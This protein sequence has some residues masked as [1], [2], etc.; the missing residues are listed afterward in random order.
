MNNYNIRSVT[1]IK[2]VT[3]GQSFCG[4][5]TIVNKLLHPNETILAEITL[6]CCYNLLNINNEFYVAIWDTA[7]LEKYAQ[8]IKGYFRDVKVFLLVFDVSNH[9]A[10]IEGLKSY[11]THPE[12]E[13]CD[14]IFII[15][16]KMDFEGKL[17]KNEINKLMRKI[18]S[19]VKEE[20]Q[21]YKNKNIKY[22]SIS[23]QTGEGVDNLRNE[24]V[25]T[26]GYNNNEPI[27][28]LPP[29]NKLDEIIILPVRELNV[30]EPKEKSFCGK[31]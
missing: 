18:E 1:P 17:T 4:K 10:T 5:T 28:K 31:C 13:E 19:Y 26:C 11:L 3:L 22:F 30:E 29:S 20:L 7:G 15:G 9:V 14:N 12:V 23:A 8:L 16:N 24:L 25:Y 27:D 2:V 21:S 6:G